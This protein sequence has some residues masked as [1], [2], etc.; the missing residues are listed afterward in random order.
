MGKIGN[1]TLTVKQQAFVDAYNGNTKAAAKAAGLS[2][3]YC[4]RLMMDVSKRNAEPSALAVQTAIR[5]RQDHE[6]RSRVATRLQR[7]QFWTKM[8]DDATEKASDRL[9]ASMLLGKSE[10]DF[11][12]VVQSEHTM[13]LQLGA[14]RKAVESEAIDKTAIIESKTGEPEHDAV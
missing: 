13:R 8:M 2:Q 3:G 5:D 12:D 14:P 11:V 10:A 1:D 7:Q 4:A 6:R 9:Q